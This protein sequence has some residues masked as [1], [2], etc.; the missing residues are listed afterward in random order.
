MSRSRASLDC[1][2]LATHRSTKCGLRRAAPEQ[3]RAD[4]EQ[5]RPR[6]G[7]THAAAERF[8]VARR[9][10]IEPL[11]E[12]LR[13]G[14]DHAI[15]GHAMEPLRLVA[16]R[17]VPDDHLVRH[18]AYQRFARQ[19]VPA[20]HAQRAAD[21][22]R[23]RRT[24]VIELRRAELDERR[25]EQHV[26][27]VLGDELV[28][29]DLPRHRPLEHRQHAGQQS[30]ERQLRERQHQQRRPLVGALANLRR[31]LVARIRV[32]QVVEPDAQRA[33][34]PPIASPL[35]NRRESDA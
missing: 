12:A 23:P 33:R 13:A 1:L 4:I 35:Q 8:A 9:R 2:M 26:G 6:A 22:E 15:G 21:A 29:A 31:R 30:A 18:D 24:H 28:H 17:G 16:L 5:E 14:D 10:P 32:A 11:I 27:L 34:Q 25:D 3:R 20:P 19:V 7:E